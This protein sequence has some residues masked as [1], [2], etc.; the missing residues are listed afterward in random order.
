M[1]SPLCTL[2]CQR[3]CLLC[4]TAE[5][6]FHGKGCKVI[7]STM[8]YPLLFF[9]FF[10]FQNPNEVTSFLWS[11][12]ARVSLGLKCKVRLDWELW[13]KTVPYVG[14][15]REEAASFRAQRSHP[16]GGWVLFL[17]WF[18]SFVLIGHGQALGVLRASRRGRKGESS[19]KHREPDSWTV[20]PSHVQTG[21]T[22]RPTH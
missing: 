13:S 4:L 7:K 6:C 15:E 9:F 2:R 10:L 11:Q 18:P 22:G 3:W 14:R 19:G 1:L 16:A 17:G 12:S 20:T 8:N 5:S 21:T